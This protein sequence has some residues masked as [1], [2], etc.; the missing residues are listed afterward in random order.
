M[1]VLALL[2]AATLAAALLVL[3]PPTPATAQASD[4][5]ETGFVPPLPTPPQQDGLPDLDELDPIRFEYGDA[6]VEA[7]QIP[8]R[9]RESGDSRQAIDQIWIDVIRPVT[10]EPLPTV[11]MASPYY[12][13][14]GRGWRGEFKTPANEAFGPL[15]GAPGLGSGEPQVG[16]PEWYDEYF[17]PRGYAYVAMDLRGTRNSSGC[18]V[19]GDRD[20]V[21][22]AV[23]VIDWIADQ[24]WSNGKVAMTGG[25]YDGT[26]ANGVAAEQPISGRHPEALAAATPIRSIGRWYDYHFF[27]GV[28]SSSHLAT[29]ALFTAVLAGEDTQNAPE[30]DVLDP[31]HVAERKACIATSAPRSTPATPRRTRTPT[32][33]SGPSAPS[34]RARPA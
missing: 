16:F 5:A 24:P 2:L 14:L 29:P 23:D 3:P 10:D 19:Y 4:E 22:D 11:M 13:T 33:P 15:V 31:L 28:Q 1:R 8:V 6:T 9:L 20:E 7:F 32:R 12:N 17:V 34:P 27:N 26:I 30:E 18:Q 21:Y 25:S